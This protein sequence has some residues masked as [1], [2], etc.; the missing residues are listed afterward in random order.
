MSI[1]GLLRILESL[2]QFYFRF[3]N[4]I[5]ITAIKVRL[6]I[7]NLKF[8]ANGYGLVD[9][10]L[11]NRYLDYETKSII[12]YSRKI[13]W[14]IKFGD[15][16]VYVITVKLKFAKISYSHICVWR[17]CTEPPNLNP[18]YNILA[19][20]ILGSTAKFNSR[21][22]FRLYGIIEGRRESIVHGY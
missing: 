5:E 9:E 2:S 4:S 6:L 11:I 20:A 19:I 22:Y 16:A 1:L 13:W 17:S 8:R 7:G 3:C 14:G 15:L 10:L 12:P 21:Q 18:L